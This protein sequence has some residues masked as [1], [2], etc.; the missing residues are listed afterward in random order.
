MVCVFVFCLESLKGE[1]WSSCFNSGAKERWRYWDWPNLLK[2][3]GA[4]WNDF[5]EQD[6]GTLV[7]DPEHGWR[8]E[9]GNLSVEESG[10]TFDADRLYSSLHFTGTSGLKAPAKGLDFY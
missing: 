8:L 9:Q 7:R 10:G 6:V 3:F 5:H 2:H 1:S 4:K